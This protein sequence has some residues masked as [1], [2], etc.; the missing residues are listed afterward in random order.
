MNR[1]LTASDDLVQLLG[2]RLPTPAQG[3]AALVTALVRICKSR[4]LSLDACVKLAYDLDETP[5][6]AN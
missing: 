4:G 6:L 3:A 5:R 1:V 2:E